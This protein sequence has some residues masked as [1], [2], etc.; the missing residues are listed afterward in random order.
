MTIK[1]ILGCL[2]VMGGAYYGYNHYFANN[3]ES[4]VVKEAA[5]VLSD[6]FHMPVEIESFVRLSEPN[7]RNL[8]L[9][10]MV[11]NPHNDL[12][13]SV[14]LKHSRRTGK[15]DQDSF[16]RFAQDWAGLEF[17]NTLNTAVAIAPRFYGGNKEHRFIVLE[18]LGEPHVSLVDCLT[19]V[20]NA[21]AAIDS[22]QRFMI[23][24]G[25][26]HAHGY[27][28]TDEYLTIL[29]TLNPSVMTKKDESAE[30]IHQLESTFKD[31]QISYSAD[32]LDIISKTLKSASE[33]GPFTTFIHG[34]ICPDNT[35]DNPKKK[36][37]L[38]IDFEK[39]KIGN[40][41]LDATYLRMSMP[42]CWC[43]KA[44]PAEVI[45]PLELLYRQQLIDKIPAAKSDEIYY[46]AYVS[47]CAYWMI[48]SLRSIENV[49]KKDDTWGISSVRSRIVSHLQAFIAVA[50]QYNQLPE[51]KSLAEDVLQKLKT[52]WPDTKPLD[53]F[54]AFMKK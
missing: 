39:G 11:K 33:T 51:L 28:H 32:S 48:E 45:Q 25:Q 43:A 37:F 7:R 10:L 46:A 22:L 17:V 20:D 18:D 41:L 14:I 24:L 54:P 42:T 3:I 40:A 1:L 26:L 13:K 21:Q 15:G 52:Q 19:A 6:T 47:A 23:C 12:P 16:D 29:H 44:L 27:Q 50:N 2:L 34:D 30:I 4:I 31:L 9:R 8:V 35:F 5:K 38:L 53:M 49:Q 36:T